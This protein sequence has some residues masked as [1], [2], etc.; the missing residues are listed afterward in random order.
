MPFSPFFRGRDESRT[1]N[2]GGYDP[3][4]L[5]TI[6]V[7]RSGC[8]TKARRRSLGGGDPVGIAFEDDAAGSDAEDGGIVHAG[9]SRAMLAQVTRS[10]EESTTRTDDHAIAGAQVLAGSV[11]DRAHALGHGLVLQ[12]NTADAGVAL[13]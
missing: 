7:S 9:R 12:V 11:V 1:T 10:L 6:A 4:M 13:A 8:S 5:P 3:G 2:G